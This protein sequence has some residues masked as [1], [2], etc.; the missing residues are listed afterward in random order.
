MT[1]EVFGLPVY[2]KISGSGDKT[3]V[4]LQGWGT[5][6][7]LYDSL[8]EVISERFRVVQFDFPGFGYSAEPDKPWDVKQYTD[9]L[10]AFLK[11]LDISE[12]IFIAHS[13]GGRVAI[14]TASRSELPVSID[15]MVLMDSAGI[16]PVRTKKSE[17][18]VKRY[19]I[20]KKITSLKP[21]Y[22][23]FT[24]LIDDWRGR[25]GSEDYKNASPVMKKT[26]VMAVNYDQTAL[27][28]S[29][30]MPV[31]LVWGDGDTATPL[32]D[33]YIMDEKLPDSR[34]RIIEN[35]GHFSFL[36]KPDEADRVI[37]DFLKGGM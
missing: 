29:V 18:R 32:R 27:L 35:T 10:I 2:Y 21:V 6:C 23:M 33:A 5:K 8:A 13:F 25:Q 26:L 14:E 11:E 17:F 24:D 4:M 16:L 9:F 37:M 22:S 20:I 12:V 7:E 30:K 15:R 19:K 31:L 1:T 36:E 34:L 28:S 3:V